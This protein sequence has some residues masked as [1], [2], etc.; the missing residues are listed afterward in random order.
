MAIL[1]IGN[2]AFSLPVPSDSLKRKLGVYQIHISIDIFPK[3]NRMKA[4][5]QSLSELLAEHH[6]L[7]SG[8]KNIQMKT[9]KQKGRALNLLALNNSCSH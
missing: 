4:A 5:D 9:T 3:R 2:I 6:A 7:L 1:Q 8:Q